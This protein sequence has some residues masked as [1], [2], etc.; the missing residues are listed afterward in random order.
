MKK[1]LVRVGTLAIVV[2]VLLGIFLNTKMYKNMIVDNYTKSIMER[3]SISENEDIDIQIENILKIHG[4]IVETFTYDNYHLQKIATYGAENY[5]LYQLYYAFTTGEVSCTTEA[6]IMQHLLS[7]INIDCEVLLLLGDKVN[8]AIPI[9]L[10]GEKYYGFD[11]GADRKLIQLIGECAYIAVGFG[12]DTIETT[13]VIEGILPEDM[14]QSGGFPP[15][16]S[17]LSEE[18]LDLTKYLDQ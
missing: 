1:H 8:H 14:T 6:I 5:Y 17:N 16:P 18:D 2:I 7:E 9:V 15:I 3:L 4:Y 12:S 10:I 13:Y 11:T